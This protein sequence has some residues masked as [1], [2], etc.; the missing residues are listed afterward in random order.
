MS[1]LLPKLRRALGLP[2][3]ADKAAITQAFQAVIDNEE[4]DAEARDPRV[5]L[6]RAA[7]ERA[8]KKG[9]GFT[10]ALKELSEESPRLVQAVSDF[11][12]RER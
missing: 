7:E 4:D 12:A 5:V 10:A 8:R 6:T 11:Y 3:S 2:A 9:I 1:D